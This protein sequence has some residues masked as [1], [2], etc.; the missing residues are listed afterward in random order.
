MKSINRNFARTG[1]ARKNLRSHNR[2]LPMMPLV[3]PVAFY[4]THPLDLNCTV[5]CLHKLIK[6]EIAHF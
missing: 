4:L 1:S 3:L 2:E 6:I 5:A